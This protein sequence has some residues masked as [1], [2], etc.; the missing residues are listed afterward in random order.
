MEEASLFVRVVSQVLWSYVE[1][2]TLAAYAVTCREAAASMTRSSRW[3]TLY[4]RR[5]ALQDKVPQQYSAAE[6]RAAALMRGAMEEESQ[7]EQPLEQAVAAALAHANGDEDRFFAF[8]NARRELRRGFQSFDNSFPMGTAPASLHTVALSFHDGGSG[9]ISGACNVALQTVVAVYLPCSIFPLYVRHEYHASGYNDDPTVEGTT[10]VCVSSLK[11]RKP[12][13]SR[14]KGFVS[15]WTARHRASKQ[16][17]YLFRPA[18]NDAAATAAAARFSSK[19]VPVLRIRSLQKDEGFGGI[20]KDESHIARAFPVFLDLLGPLVE[21][22][23]K[24]PSAR[25]RWAIQESR[26]RTECSLPEC[27]LRY[28]EAPR[29]LNQGI[30]DFTSTALSDAMHSAA[31]SPL[32][33]A[34][35]NGDYTEATKLISSENVNFC[36]RVS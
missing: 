30:S 31:N 36:S 33:T 26:T 9:G 27:I 22:Y 5:W 7:R 2:R 20:L 11:A 1:P 14:W 10:S 12:L 34:I 25:H 17:A 29:A 8:Y 19:F 32:L 6:W 3:E 18:P 16:P 21:V 23:L 15:A 24:N 35:E 4:R 28:C 13:P